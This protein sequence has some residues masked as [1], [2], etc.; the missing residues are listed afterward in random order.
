MARKKKAVRK[1]TARRK[2]KLTTKVKT[3]SAN[4]KLKSNKVIVPTGQMDQP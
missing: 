1:S 2:R 3:P 4:L